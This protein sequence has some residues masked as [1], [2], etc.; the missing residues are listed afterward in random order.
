MKPDIKSSI[1]SY[2]IWVLHSKEQTWSS[3]GAY[4]LTCHSPEFLI[5]NLN[6]ENLLTY[7]EFKIKRIPKPQTAIRV[8]PKMKYYEV[9]VTGP[10][11]HKVKYFGINEIDF[12][13]DP[14]KSFTKYQY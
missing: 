2:Q 12:R 10:K 9:E 1:R 5:I 13:K 14:K 8:P 7:R 6:A 11:Y 3:I 4:L